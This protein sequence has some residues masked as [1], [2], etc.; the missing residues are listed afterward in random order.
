MKLGGDFAEQSL[1]TSG[2]RHLLEAM[3]STA[4]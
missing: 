1:G 2:V 3:I 4:Q